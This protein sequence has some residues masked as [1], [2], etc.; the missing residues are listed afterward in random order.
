M[1]KKTSSQTAFWVCFYRALATRSQISA[2]LPDPMAEQFLPQPL[3]WLAQRHFMAALFKRLITRHPNTHRTS[4]I[5]LRQRFAEEA[6]AQ[7]MTQQGVKQYII[8]GA[9]LDSFSVRKPSLVAQLHVFELDHPATQAAKRALLSQSG[10]P[11]PE[12]VHFVAID[13]ENERIS[14]RLLASCFDPSQKTF[15]TWMGVSYYLHE[16]TIW[17]VLRELAQ[18]CQAGCVICF[19]YARK[20]DYTRLSAKKARFIRYFWHCVHIGM[21]LIGEPFRSLFH[22]QY[23]HEQLKNKGFTVNEDLSVADYA[24]QLTPEERGAFT[25]AGHTRLVRTSH[26]GLQIRSQV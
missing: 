8:L 25:A 19:D 16:D 6:L 4:Q 2:I 3:R 23:L 9:G 22:T 17:A 24:K 10:H 7:A 14:E 1:R 11:L 5:L 12:H 20:P 21:R 26:P 15:I 18:T 13:F